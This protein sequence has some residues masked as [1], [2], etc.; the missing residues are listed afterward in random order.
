MIDKSR[1]AINENCKVLG[2]GVAVKVKV[3]T[4]SLMVLSL[5]FTATPNFCS[6]SIIKRPKSLNFILGFTN[7]CVPMTISTAPLLSPLIT[8]LRCLVVLKRFK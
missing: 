3:S 7:W 5:S 6:S 8:S 2:I 4:F 1:A